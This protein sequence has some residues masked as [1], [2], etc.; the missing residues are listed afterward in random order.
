[1]IVVTYFYFTFFLI[2]LGN[3]LGYFSYF[4]EIY[5]HGQNIRIKFIINNIKSHILYEKNYKQ[6]PPR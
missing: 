6:F 4:C 3:R 1:M 2:I 5:I